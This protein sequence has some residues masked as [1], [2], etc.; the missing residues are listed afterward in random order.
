MNN[1]IF[2]VRSTSI[3]NDS[4]ASKE[5]TSLLNNK[6]NVTV[7]G[8]DR[9]K[10]IKN[11]NNVTLN[12][13]KINCHFFKFNAGYGESIVNVI[14]LFL[15]Q[16]WLFFT[17]FVHH[18]KYKY[19][20]ACDFDCGF[21]SMIISK[22]FKKKLIYDMYDYYSDSR[23]MSAKV[24]KIINNLENRV[25]NNSEVSIICGEWRFEQIKD[26][27]PKKVVIIHNTPDIRNID[28]KSLIK[29][30]NKKIKIGYVG[31][32]Q[33][34]RL[35]I[36]ILEKLKDNK[37]YELHIGGFG[38]YEK[39]IQELSENHKNIYFYGSLPYS[40]VLCLEQECDILFATYDP[41]IKNHKFSAP[42]K[43]YE[44][45]ALGKPI[46]VCKDTGIDKL[47]IENEIGL[48]TEY[49]ADDFAKK[50]EDLI[51]NKDKMIEMGDKAKKL[52]NRKYNWISMEKEL[53][54][55]YES[56]GE[57]NDYHINTNI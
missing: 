24:E 17:L 13:H 25:I 51:K 19:I 57:A 36:E 32:L 50:L 42:N 41:S 21:I 28:D 34:H 40:D 31:I 30:S 43:I 53:I 29:S 11:Y 37:K 4:R 27:I 48:S 49:N 5:I 46:I 9:D 39:Y 1:S 56:L 47:V 22:L 6:Y 38:K 15:F 26:A 7:L 10:K 18:K 3:I 16:I 2:Y 33:D 20:H 55:I 14:G 35:I 54:K 44:A 12:N 45:M 52:Y 23:P 8:W